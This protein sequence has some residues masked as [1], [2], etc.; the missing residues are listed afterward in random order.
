M[1]TCKRGLHQYEGRRCEVCARAAVRSWEKRHPESVK[2][3]IKRSRSKPSVK[4]RQAAY[5]QKWREANRAAQ[6]AKALARYYAKKAAVLIGPST[7]KVRVWRAAHPEATKALRIQNEAT[8]RARKAGASGTHT[9]AEWEAICARQRN[10]CEACGDECK[11]TKD[12]IVPLSMGGSN[13]ASNLQGLCGP[14]NSRKG[15]R[16]AI[17]TNLTVR[18]IVHG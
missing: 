7:E 6:N 12:H 14:C 2:A 1:K 4:A 9:Q 10:L 11:L 8:R 5:M 15:A 16:I 13:D 3:S 17:D 18:E